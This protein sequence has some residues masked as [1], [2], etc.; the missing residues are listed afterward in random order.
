VNYPINSSTG[1][2]IGDTKRMVWMFGAMT[3]IGGIA[4][5]FLPWYDNPDYYRIAYGVDGL[6]GVLIRCIR[7]MT[8]GSGV[9][10]VILMIISSRVEKVSAVAPASA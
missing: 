6:F 4:S 1:L 2:G 3:L 7:W 9:L 5:F 10:T 8:V